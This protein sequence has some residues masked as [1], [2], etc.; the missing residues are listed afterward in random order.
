MLPPVLDLT[1]ALVRIPSLSG[2]EGAVAA[3]VADAMRRLGFDGVHTDAWGNVIG[4]RRGSRPG[5]T[6]LFDGHMDVVE[7][8]PEGWLRDPYGGEISQG[9]L[10]GRGACDTKGSLAAMLCAAAE[11]P[12]H[13]LAGTLVMAATVCEETVTGAALGH[14]L[15]AHPADLVVTGEPTGLR[16]GVAQK[17]RATL[18]LRA[19]GRS[20]HTSQPEL[21]DNAVYRMIEAIERLRALPLPGDPELGPGVLELV[22][23]ESQPLPNQTL[24]PA[25]CQAR[26]VART[27]PGEDAGA[28]L[29]RIERGLTGLPGISFALDALR[30]PCYTGALLETVDFLPGWRCPEDDPWRQAL[31]A[32]L[33]TAGLLAAIYAAPCGTNASES[34]GRR[35]IPSFIYGPGLLAEAHIAD[36]W[37]DIDE[38]AAAQTGFHIIARQVL[39]GP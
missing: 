39:G 28:L 4:L 30:Q 21:G 37:V 7:P 1:R 34:A 14:V 17:G 8:G 35:G 29:S 26:F 2:E 27:M 11:L 15:D 31:L 12:V 25:G 10:W 13:R 24:V 20:A 23:I 22:E 16:L 5:P 33:A 9:R 19:A 3:F 36:E 38:L 18:R 6:L 32:A